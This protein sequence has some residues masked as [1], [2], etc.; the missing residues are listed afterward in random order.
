MESLVGHLHGLPIETISEIFFQGLGEMDDFDGDAKY[1]NH[2]TSTCSLWR[3]IALLTPSLWT[4]VG[5]IDRDSGAVSPALARRRL[6]RVS[7]YLER[8]GGMPVNLTVLVRGCSVSLCASIWEIFMPQLPRCH[9]LSI[10]ILVPQPKRLKLFFPLPA[11]VPRLASLQVQALITPATRKSQ[12]FADDIGTLP[13]QKLVLSSSFINDRSMKN[14]PTKILTD[15][16]IHTS[17]YELQTTLEFLRKCHALKRLKLLQY[18]TGLTTPLPDSISPLLFPRLMSLDISNN[19]SLGFRGLILTPMLEELVLSWSSAAW[20]WPSARDHS[21]V[22]SHCLHTLTIKAFIP[23]SLN[24]L[25]SLLQLHP[26]ITKLNV[27]DSY[28]GVQLL[29]WL[30]GAEPASDSNE[31]SNWSPYNG[32]RRLPILRSLSLRRCAVSKDRSDF[33]SAVIELLCQRPNLQLS[34]NPR[35]LSDVT[36]PLTLTERFGGRVTF[37]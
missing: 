29:S 30:T 13:L 34:I 6:D 5:W 35:D 2:I 32:I 9:A 23:A 21:T 7:A 1:L 25:S 12:I 19:D 4:N 15:V 18:G 36:S 27:Q 10:V 20:I 14:I 17:D 3:T 31:A 8:S 11:P 26:T 16:C 37:N 24:N 33:T 22:I 28:L